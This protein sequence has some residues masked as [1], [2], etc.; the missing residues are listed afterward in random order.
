MRSHKTSSPR[1]E[2]R[3]KRFV[4]PARTATAP[5]SGIE[6]LRLQA[7][8][9]RVTGY[10]GCGCP[11]IGLAADRE[12]APQSAFGT[13]LVVETHSDPKDPEDTLWLLLWTKDGWLS[14]LELAWISE[15]APR[16]LPPPESFQLFEPPFEGGSRVNRPR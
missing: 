16:L 4:E 9:A 14:Y 10:C 8:T 13:R 11:G 5:T 3:S 7:E 15:A 6:A 12:T 2:R 1:C